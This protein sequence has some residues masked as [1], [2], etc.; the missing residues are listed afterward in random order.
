VCIRV[1]AE[2]ELAGRLVAEAWEAAHA[3]LEERECQGRGAIF[4]LYTEA[5]QAEVVRRA[6]LRIVRDLAAVGAAEPVPEQDWSRSW[7]AGLRAI[8]VSP[9]LVVRP[10]FISHR[11]ASGQGEIVIDPGQAFGTGHHASTLLALRLLESALAELAAPAHVLDVGTGSGVLALC[12]L[13]LG[14]A[15]ALAFDRDPQA[16]HEASANARANGLSGSL[17]LF[18]GDVGALRPD[19]VDLLVANLLSSE[20]LP[21]LP[22]LAARLREGGRGIFSGLLASERERTAAALRAS[23]LCVL[24]ERRSP[25]ERGEVWLALMTQR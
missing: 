7:K 10:S 4:L 24:D 25:D 18:A 15:L 21:L 22:S 5:G 1:R 2:A 12:A 23:G 6:A 11:L 9:R 3:G 16:V 17:H 13:R 19:P 14:A 8:V 20:L